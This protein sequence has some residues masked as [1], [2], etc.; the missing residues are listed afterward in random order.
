MGKSV[1][2][3][4][5]QNLNS[6]ERLTCARVCEYGNENVIKIGNQ[7]LK[8]VDKVTFLGIIIDDKLNWEPHIDHLAQ[9]LKSSIIMIKRIMKFIPNNKIYDALFKS[10]L[11]YCISS[12]AAIPNYKLQSI[13]SIQKRC[14]RLLFGTQYSYDH[15]G[16]FAKCTRVRTYQQHTSPRNYCLEHTKPLFKKHSIMTIKNM[17]VYH[18]FL[19]L[20]KNLK[21]HIPIS[22]YSIFN[23]SQ[24]GINFKL[25]LPRVTL[26]IS[27][28][29]FV[30]KSCSLWNSL[31]GDILERS[32]AGTNWI[33]VRGY[34]LNSDL[35]APVSF[36]KNKLR[37]LMLN[38]QASGDTLKWILENSLKI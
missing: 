13:F 26:D 6:N 8:K 28:N 33:I 38:H 12:W 20:F 15:A 32:I 9:K 25:H 23:Q 29:N 24:R 10:H 34:A 37:L 1:H 11:S 16:Y 27:K 36:I 4:F 31:I 14:I 7:K 21:T 5:R 35:C 30:F 3:H 17:Y 18:T 22:L 19:D 2:M